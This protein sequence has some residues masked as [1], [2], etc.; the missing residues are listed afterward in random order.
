MR[1][2]FI[3]HA[4]V[5]FGPDMPS[6]DWH[7]SPAGRAT[8]EA[9]AVNEVWQTI[10]VVYASSEPKAISTAQRIA[11]PSG[12]PLF[13]EPDL[14]EVERPWVGEGSYRTVAERFLRGESIDGW[15]DAAAVER[16]VSMALERIAGI[17]PAA[18][19]SHGLALTL[20]LAL[21]LG[22][23]DEQAVAMWSDLR[24]PDVGVMDWPGGPFDGWSGSNG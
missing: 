18:I 23:T 22:L 21:V 2:V 7:L 15:E 17:G 11:A 1:L 24:F 20:I 16:R 8:A 4:A 14:R 10:N 19:V 3:R 5:T 13:I 9:L 6:R 12:L